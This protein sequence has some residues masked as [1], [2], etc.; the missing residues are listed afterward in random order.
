M[1]APIPKLILASTSPYRRQQLSLLGLP[2]E[3]ARP[4]IDESVLAGETPRELALRLSGAKAEA[5]ARAQPDAWVIAGDQVAECEGQ[6]LNK[7]ET[8]SRALAQLSAMQGRVV[9]FHTGIAL[10]ASGQ[11]EVDVVA[12]Q[13]HYLPLT[14]DQIEAYLYRDQPYDCAGSAKVERLGIAL[15]QSVQSNDPS[16]LTGLPLIRLCAMLRAAG[17]EPLTAAREDSASEPSEPPSL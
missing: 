3:V 7:P 11:L 13:A 5:I 12:V 2:F 1:P 17:L 15:M 8:H 10:W 6:I 4:G 16:A 9:T 14:H